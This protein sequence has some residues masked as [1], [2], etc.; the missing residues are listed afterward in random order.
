[1]EQK[2]TFKAWRPYK[3]MA[4][5]CLLCL[6]VLV[7]ILMGNSFARYR[8]AAERVHNPSV[9]EFGTVVAWTDRD[10]SGDVSLTDVVAGLPFAVQNNNP[11]IPY[12]V[13]VTWT[14]GDALPLD[15]HLYAE[16]EELTVTREGDMYRAQV[17]MPLGLERMDF[18]LVG[19]WGA[20]EYDERFNDVT[21]TVRMNVVCEQK[22]VS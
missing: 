3:R 21:A 9:L 16:D 7:S 22:Q 17:V 13:Y 5:L 18:V 10:W 19:T 15:F 20:E 6:L 11:T 14:I 1:M 8:E 4:L 2:T 12:T